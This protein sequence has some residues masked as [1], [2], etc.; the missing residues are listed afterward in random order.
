MRWKGQ[1]KK[2][3]PSGSIKALDEL[4]DLPHLY[5]LLR[6]V[7][8]HRGQRS[9]H[10]LEVAIHSE[11]NKKKET[12]NVDLLAVLYLRL[13]LL[14]PQESFVK[15]R[16]RRCLVLSHRPPMKRKLDEHE[17]SRKRLKLTGSGSKSPESPATTSKSP[18]LLEMEVGPNASEDIKGKGKK[19]EESKDSSKPHDQKIR[20]PH[21]RINKLVPPRPYPTVPASVSATGPRS[22]H[23]EGK[24]LICI[25]RKTSLACYLRRCK[26]VII[27]DG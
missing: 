7:L 16:S 11:V 20:H 26:D 22:N 10:F 3:V 1:K 24:N 5:V 18:P 14:R 2:V 21:R 19:K 15:Q 23:K 27:K 8:T 12:K 13:Y 17:D 6:N 4:L 25:T 9:M